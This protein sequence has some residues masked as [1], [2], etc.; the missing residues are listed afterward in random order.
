M[1][2][3]MSIAHNLKMKA[4]PS[5][6]PTTEFNTLKKRIWFLKREIRY[7]IDFIFITRFIDIP[8]I[9]QISSETDNMSAL[10]HV[11]NT[12]MTP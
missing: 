8:P 4:W 7:Y 12:K 3:A 2:R 5:A 9:P 1:K 6:T 11:K 10:K